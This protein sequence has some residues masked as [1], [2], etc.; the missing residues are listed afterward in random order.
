VPEYLRD[1]SRDITPPSTPPLPTSRSR[2]PVARTIALVLASAALASSA[3]FAITHRSGRAAPSTTASSTTAS[4]T[5]AAN[6]VARVDEPATF[7]GWVLV[8]KRYRV[9]RS[10]KG[11]PARSDRRWLIIDARLTNSTG[12]NRDFTPEMI[13]ARTLSFTGVAA[14]T[15]AM[16]G[17]VWEPPPHAT[18]SGQFIFSVS[19]L[20]GTFSL[21]IR[22][23]ILSAKSRG[24]SVEIDLNCC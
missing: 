6:P 13:E 17:A 7:D 2:M 3:T 4:G 9:V 1:G 8:V 18:I 16:P 11:F 14:Y 20:A 19:A 5:E 12:S 22:R 21:V 10:M 24:D 15:S 23:E